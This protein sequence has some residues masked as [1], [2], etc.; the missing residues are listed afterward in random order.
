MRQCCK[1]SPK[2]GPAPPPPAPARGGKCGAQ[3]R[4]DGCL[5]S[6]GAGKCEECASSHQSDLKA[7]GCTPAK[8]KYLCAHN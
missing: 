8:V 2:P 1:L 7:A 6:A 4:K 3:L 5:A